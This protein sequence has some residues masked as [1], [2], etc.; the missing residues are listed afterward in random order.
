MRSAL[1]KG[2][3]ALI[4]DEAVADVSAAKS[5]VSAANVISIDLIRPNP[6]QP[7]RTFS[8][9]SLS[10]LVASIQ[11]KGILQPLVVSETEGGIYE[12]IAGERRFRAAQ[13]AGLKEVPVVLRQGS[14]VERF[15]MALIE[16]LQREDLN[17]MDLAE[18]FRRL[19]DE[20]QL[21]QEKIA[22]VVGKARTAVANI[23]RLLGLPEEI[24]MAIKE[25]KITEGHAKALL[26]VEDQAAQKA[27]FEKI[28]SDGL[29]VRVVESAARD[30]KQGK[31]KEHIRA[32][33]YDARPP[34]IR[35]QEEELQG[36]LTRKVEIH[37]AGPSSHKGWI[38]LEFYSL[39]DF[40]ALVQKL[41]S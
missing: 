14:E 13:R 18:G 12:I 27:L 25:G 39:D 6:K 30:Q 15:E 9:D 34:E 7:R 33:G 1:G 38:K 35:A 20:F 36:T 29:T 8:E 3:D 16:N 19:Q 41:K 28:L 17:A 5:K 4:S 21:T 37:T 23:L 2:L 22:Q 40:D 26:S 11:Q 24:Q 10:D 32:A 31:K